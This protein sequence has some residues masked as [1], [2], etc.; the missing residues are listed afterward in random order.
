MV[1]NLQAFNIDFFEKQENTFS[2]TEKSKQ[3]ANTSPMVILAQFL[4]F[5]HK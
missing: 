3:S 2:Q 4:R 5:P 1:Q